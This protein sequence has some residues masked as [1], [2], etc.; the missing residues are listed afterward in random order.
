[1]KTRP[2]PRKTNQFVP[3]PNPFVSA[4]QVA[5]NFTL[6]ENGALTNKSTLSSVLDF[7]GA[8]GAIRSR[9]ESDVI[10]LFSKAFSEDRLI[11]LKTLFYIRDVREGQGERQTSRVLFSWLAKNYADVL[12]KN[13][14]NIAF[15]GRYDD[16]YSL[17]GTPLESDVFTIFGNQLKADLKNMKNGE[18]V[19]L[20]AKWLKSENTSSP[21]SRQLGYKT[22]QALELTP[23][24]YRK[25]LSALRKHIDVL[26]TKMCAGD[27]AAINFERVPSKASMN[28][29]KAFGRHDQERYAA[30]LKAVEKGEAKMNA[31]AVYPYELL[32]SVVKGCPS[33]QEILQADLQWKNMPNW[34]EGNEHYGMVIADLSGSMACDDSLP[35]LTAVS[36]AMYFAERNVGPFKDIWMNFSS[37]PSFQK[38]VGNNIYE[39]YKNMDD[40]H[41]S[42]STNLLAAFDLILE[43]SVRNKIAQKDMPS[44]LI[45]CSDME[46]NGNLEIT[47][48]DAIKRKYSNAG[49]TVP[50]LVWWN[51]SARNDNNP[52]RHDE[53][54]TALVSGCSP[55]IFKS[56]MNGKEFNPMDILYD[57][58]N[59]PRYERV[60]I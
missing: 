12:R 32:R 18:S 5:S 30:Y 43:T 52:I 28:Y 60:I 37:T 23:K 20:L 3:K 26:E 24:R 42:Q 17:V 15:F 31:S 56:V 41:W 8:A 21:A 10:S 11:A 38:L 48:M 22:R 27:W 47:T 49:Y 54:G 36:L 44:V 16:L 39:K 1:M 35:L 40:K 58:V 50:R 53:N 33:A 19:S 6:T 14:E 51:V 46:F 29:R 57:T 55:S 25:I 9:S 7:F 34:L 59:S 45:V 4:M 2:I 13:L